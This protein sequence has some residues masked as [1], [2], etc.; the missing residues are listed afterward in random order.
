[1]VYAAT[2]IPCFSRV[3]CAD[4]DMSFIELRNAFAGWCDF[5]PIRSNTPHTYGVTSF[6][7]DSSD[8]RSDVMMASAVL[9]AIVL[10]EARSTAPEH[11]MVARIIRASI[12]Q[13]RRGHGYVYTTPHRFFNPFDVNCVLCAALHA[14]T[15][16][17]LSVATAWLGSIESAG[18][19]L[20][21]VAARKIA[22]AINESAMFARA[23]ERGYA[24]GG[25]LAEAL[26]ESFAREF[27]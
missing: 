15:H 5:N 13:L 21:S 26:R 24:P 1:M 22:R 27:D 19:K 3:A 10:H 6:G 20:R 4:A 17:L 18:T 25:P 2:H 23:M 11:A 9:H 8:V 12:D 14:N 7:L 16:G